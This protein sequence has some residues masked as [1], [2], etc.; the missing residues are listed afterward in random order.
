VDGIDLFR[1]VAKRGPLGVAQACR[2][3]R[4]AAL[5]L[6]AAHT[7]GLVHRD[8]KPLNLLLSREGKVK[9][10]DLGLARL[11]EYA[12]EAG[13]SGLTAAGQVMG[14]PDYMAPEQ[15]EDSRGAGV[16]ADLYALGCTLFFL[17]NGRAPFASERFGSVATKMRAHLSE[18]PPD[19]VAARPDAPPGLCE[20][21]RRLLAK[22]PKDR[23]ASATSVAEALQRFTGSRSGG[24]DRTVPHA[25]VEAGATAARLEALL[26]ALPS[27]GSR[28]RVG[29]RSLWA[30]IAAVVSVVALACAVAWSV[31]RNSDRGPTNATIGTSRV[32]SG[33]PEA[34]APAADQPGQSEGADAAPEPRHATAEV[35][36]SFA[37]RFDGTTTHVTIPTLRYDG[38]YPITIEATVRPANASK[39]TI[40][41]DTEF[42][43]LGVSI[44]DFIVHNG[45]KYVGA[46]ALTSP[47]RGEW[48]HVAA[49]F[50]GK[51]VSYFLNG[52]HQETKPFFG[53]YKRSPLS[54]MIGANPSW[55]NKHANHFHGLIRQI[56]ISRAARYSDDYEP[57]KTLG[58]DVDTI[59]L[60]RFDEGAGNVLHN[61]VGDRHTG[62]I[63]GPVWVRLRA[64]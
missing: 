22:D 46:T 4:Q 50:D 36:G 6:A 57:E 64:D 3:V 24:S 33:P 44:N 62:I 31:G 21:Y 35:A 58:A 16:P 10:L 47:P 39:G 1:L 60:Y 56:R 20:L 12:A 17:L 40:L 42:A 25:P 9:V 29:R 49:V 37:Q 8:V 59:A 30:A 5:G 23:P 18:P 27:E 45:K 51:R 13:V 53:K 54:L 55:D 2:I 15:W 7:Q 19:L 41:A 48:V 14:T 32:D 38:S 11:I 61:A 63:T 34:V 52:K 43:G 28:H 26:E